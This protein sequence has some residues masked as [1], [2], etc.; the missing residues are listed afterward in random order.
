M[1][2]EFSNGASKII[3]LSDDF[4]KPNLIY[5]DEPVKTNY[6]KFKILEI[7]SGERFDDTCISEI[8]VY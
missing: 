2:L 8:N 5:L 3:N 7:Y 1:E 6:I 4:S